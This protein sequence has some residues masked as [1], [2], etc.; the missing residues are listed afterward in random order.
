MRYCRLNFQ[1]WHLFHS[2]LRLVIIIYLYN[3]SHYKDVKTQWFISNVSLSF[4]ISAFP[5]RS[6][7]VLLISGGRAAHLQAVQNLYGRMDKQKTS[8]LKLDSVGDVFAQAVSL[9]NSF[10]AVK[11]YRKEYCNN[12]SSMDVRKTNLRIEFYILHFHNT[13]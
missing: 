4:K 1:V 9:P 10:Q 7:D 3:I 6:M 2:P 13:L 5:T 8:F 11:R 12:T